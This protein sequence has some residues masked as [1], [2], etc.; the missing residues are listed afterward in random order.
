MPS[1]RKTT[2]VRYRGPDDGFVL[3]VV[4]VMLVI[5]TT[6]VLFA[7]RRGTV[8][9]RLASNVRGLV[10][11]DSAAAYVLRYCEARLL[12]SPPGRLQ[13]DP[14]LPPPPPVISAPPQGAAPAWRAVLN[15]RLNGLNPL[16]STL[17]WSSAELNQAGAPEDVSR[18]ECLIEDATAELEQEASGGENVRNNGPS[19]PAQYRKYRITVEVEGPG[20]GGPR[21]ARAQSELR[22]NPN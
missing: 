18:A 8:D 17:V 21:I 14:D 6:V 20:P 16:A 5:M 22:M 19:L 9:E 2:L 3:P 13:T 7:M 10:T 1:L 15:W 11:M 4:L 12:Q